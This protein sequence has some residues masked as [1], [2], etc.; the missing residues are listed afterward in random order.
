MNQSAGPLKAQTNVLAQPTSASELPALPQAGLLSD[1]QNTLEAVYSQVNPSVVNIHVVQQQANSTSNAQPFQGFPFF[2]FPGSPNLPQNQGPQFSQAL[3]S[4]FVWDQ[5]G[6]IVTND[7]VVDGSDKIEVTLS[8]GTT[9]PAKLVGADS[10]S[11][12]AVIKI[13]MPAGQ[14]HP[15]RFFDSKQVK[16]GQ[17]AIAIGNPFGLEG[18][19]TVGIVSAMGR[20]LPAN[21]TD[22]SGLA[23][24]IPDIIQTDAPINPGNSGGVLVDDQGQVIGVTS[25]IESPNGTN[26]GIGFAIPSELV[27]RVVPALIQNGHYDHSYLG[28]SG[29]NL[30]P[31][32]A[33]A[34]KLNS[35]QRG[36]LIEDVTPGGPADKAGLRGSN[37]KISINGENVNV[38]GDVIV[39]IDNVAIKTIDDVITYLSDQTQVGQKVTLT[40]LRNGKETNV[41]VTLQ[42]RPAQTASSNTSPQPTSGSAWLGISGIGLTP[43]I[44]QAIQLN[45]DQQGVLIQQVESNSPAAQAGLQGGSKVETINGQPIRIGGDVIVAIDNQQATSMNELATFIQNAQPGQDIALTILR[46]GAQQDVMVTLGTR[47]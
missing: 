17:I 14:L 26:A 10:Q 44:A 22:Q 12:L 24:S 34:M 20:T 28:I 2:N 39:S 1:Y 47:P 19:M 16:V 25:A 13:D 45:Q 42:A 18:T 38:G 9:V 29:T 40:V 30:T 21:S 27:Q 5:N 32:M 35:D 15:V 46:N 4:G 3:G 36:A 43:E 33:K 6:Y 8:D 41:E 23:Y 31:D 7:H 37:Q 11:D